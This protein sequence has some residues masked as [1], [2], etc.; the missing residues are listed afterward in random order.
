MI[1]QPRRFLLGLALLFAAILPRAAAPPEASAPTIPLHRAA[2]AITMDGHLSDPGWKGA[3]EV[4]TFY[5]ISP[6]DDAPPPVKTTAWITYDSRY[7]YVA[8]RCEDPDPAAIRAPYTDRDGLSSDQDFVCLFLDPRNS[9]LTAQEFFVNPRGIESDAV[10][11]DATGNEDFSPDF[12][13]D[14][15]A[16]ITAS[17]WEAEIRIPFSSLRYPAADP[18]TWGIV[19]LR[20]YPRNNRYQITNVR[21]PK[22]TNCILCHEAELTGITGLPPGGHWVVA[23]YATAREQGYARG[24]PGTSFLNKPVATDTGVDAKW[25]P[26]ANT[27]VDLTLNPD[28]SQVES[29]VAQVA[30]NQRFALFYPEKRPFFMEGVDLFQTP[31]QAVYTRTITSPSW[32]ARITGKTG[33]AA[34]T[35]LVAQDRGGGSVVLPGPQY[36][37]L[38]P[39]DFSSTVSIG[40]VRE[41]FGRSYLGLMMTDRENQDGSFNRLLGPDFQWNPDDRNQF[42]GQFLFSMTRTPDRPDLSSAWNGQS[43]SA[44]ALSLN[45]SYS[46]RAWN[47]N[48]TYQ[49]VG[50]GFRAD[51]GYVPQVGYRSLKQW[52]ARDYYP[53][54]FLNQVEPY[55]NL[56]QTWDRQGGTLTGRWASGLNLH[57]VR[58]LYA[59]MAVVTWAQRAG[60][61]L[62]HFHNY[63]FT[64]NWSPGPHVTEVT[65]YA[66]LGPQVDFDNVRMGNGGTVQYEITLRPAERLALDLTGEHDWLN[67]TGETGRS[68]RLFTADVARVKAVYSFSARSY[69][70][71]IAQWVDTRRDKALYTFAVEHRSAGLQGSLLYAYRLNWQSVLYVGYGDDRSYVPRQ[72]IQPQD[73]QL[74]VKVS[75][76]F[77]R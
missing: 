38:L 43:F 71:A 17:G 76:A 63:N 39:Q 48:T 9:R 42:T 54:G 67:V 28:F 41:D 46:V 45:W 37:E 64:L 56:Q 50:E 22:G 72:G 3:A 34:Y 73:R 49:D 60:T 70:R 40:R 27:A 10:R 61:V 77:Q 6:G 25:T 19:L 33:D 15:A 36:S 2:G 75:Y 30:V 44:G 51:D 20:N 55:L 31:F 65:L 29:D 21:I 53:T 7:F 13:W 1:M 23:P 8:F 26:D 4:T 24:I 35:F 69:L 57:G 32:G 12:F 47:A 66:D 14:C 52:V 74:F 62:F 11:T 58:N 59:D 18:Q 5:D 16:R 68:G